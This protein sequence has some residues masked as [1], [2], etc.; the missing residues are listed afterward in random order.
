MIIPGTAVAAAR[1]RRS[2]PGKEVVTSRRLASIPWTVQTCRRAGVRTCR[3]AGQ[4]HPSP[5]H[6]LFPFASVQ[7][8]PWTPANIQARDRLQHRTLSALLQGPFWGARRL[9]T[10][11][12][13][14]PL[15]AQQQPLQPVSLRSAILGS[16]THTRAQGLTSTVFFPPNRGRARVTSPLAHLCRRPPCLLFIFMPLS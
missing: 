7:T 13:V 6:F 12:C 4:P 11:L 5:H 16:V 3:S 2:R 9:S 8:S 15:P 10:R 1:A 14:C